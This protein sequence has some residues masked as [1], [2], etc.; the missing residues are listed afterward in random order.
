[1]DKG[2]KNKHGIYVKTVVTPEGQQRNQEKHTDTWSTGQGGDTLCKRWK[3]NQLKTFI[4]TMMN[5]NIKSDQI[6]L[7]SPENVQQSG[8]Q[9]TQRPRRRGNKRSS[10]PDAGRRQSVGNQSATTTRQRAVVP[11]VKALLHRINSRSPVQLTQITI[12]NKSREPW[13]SWTSK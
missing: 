8:V 2:V 13:S 7:T 6:L 5:H 11:R 10:V 3:R 1:M 12:S 9:L 4:L